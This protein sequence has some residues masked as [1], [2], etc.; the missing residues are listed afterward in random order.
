MDRHART[1]HTQRMRAGASA[2]PKKFN[3]LGALGDCISQAAHALNQ[4]PFYVGE[5]AETTP[6][7]KGRDAAHCG[8]FS[9]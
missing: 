7:R 5:H 8:R 6:T 9:T 3:T 4:I 1:K 2:A